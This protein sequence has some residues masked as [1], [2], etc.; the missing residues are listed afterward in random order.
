MAAWL[1]SE[2]L[3]SAR[4]RVREGAKRFVRAEG[5]SPDQ[6]DFSDSAEE[7]SEDLVVDVL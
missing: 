6:F 2:I 1:G 5:W 7:G 4:V 3:G